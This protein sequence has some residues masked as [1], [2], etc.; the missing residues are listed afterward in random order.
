MSV[1]T[2]RS[3]DSPLSPVAAVTTRLTQTGV[4]SPRFKRSSHDQEGAAGSA[5]V[6]W[7]AKTFF[8]RR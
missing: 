4:P 5:P 8:F 2:T 1:T 7:A 6:E 3:T